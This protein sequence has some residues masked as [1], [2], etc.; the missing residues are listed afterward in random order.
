MSREKRTKAFF[1][2]L[3]AKKNVQVRG[4]N[5]ELR[6]YHQVT[7]CNQSQE[8]IWG[9]GPQGY[10]CSGNNYSILVAEIQGTD[11]CIN[12]RLPIQIVALTSISAT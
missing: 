9:I 3:R 7:R 6:T 2:G 4:H 8:I 12:F 11:I 10:K 1:G 5:F